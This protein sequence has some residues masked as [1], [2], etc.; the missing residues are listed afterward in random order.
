MTDLRT[1]LHL[2]RLAAQGADVVD[3]HL[4]H[5]HG[6]VRDGSPIRRDWASA[7]TIAHGHGPN[8]RFSWRQ[9]RFQKPAS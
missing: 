2:M 7:H 6:H 1:Y 8:D 3:T 4:R 5:D 9:F